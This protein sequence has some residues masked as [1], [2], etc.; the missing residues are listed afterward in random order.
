METKDVNNSWD[1]AIS[2]ARNELAVVARKK[3]RLEQA[4]RIFKANKQDG[5]PWPGTQKTGEILGQ[6]G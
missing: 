1:M 4:I 5:V 3:A 6:N 2:D